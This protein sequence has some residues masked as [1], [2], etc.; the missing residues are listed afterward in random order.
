MNWIKNTG[1]KPDV[2]FVHIQLNRDADGWPGIPDTRYNQNVDN[3]DWSRAGG[4]MIDRCSTEYLWS[5]I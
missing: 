4:V 5:L 3:W 2:P 1:T